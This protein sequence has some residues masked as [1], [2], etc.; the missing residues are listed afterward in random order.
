MS[1]RGGYG[2]SEC[3]KEVKTEIGALWNQVQAGQHC[4]QPP[5]RDLENSEEDTFEDLREPYLSRSEGGRTQNDLGL[6]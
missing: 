5:G 1:G 4:Q 3:L 2:E 6:M